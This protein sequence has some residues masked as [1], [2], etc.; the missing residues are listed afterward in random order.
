MFQCWYLYELDTSDLVFFP[1]EAMLERFAVARSSAG[2]L[3]A[4]GEGATPDSALP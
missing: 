4:A 2:G 3:R 1:K